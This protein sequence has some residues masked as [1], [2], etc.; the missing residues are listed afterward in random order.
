MI[1]AKFFL[2]LAFFF[3]TLEGEELEALPP[4]QVGDLVFRQGIGAESLIIEK[5]GNFPYTH[6]AMISSLEP[7][8]LIHATTNDNANTPNQVIFSPFDEFLKQSKKIAIKRLDLNERQKEQILSFAKNKLG[9][10]FEL[11]SDENALYCT[12]FIEKALANVV[13]YKLSKSYVDFAYFRGYYLFP[14][15]FFE[16]NRSVLIYESKELKNSKKP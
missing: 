14:K 1:R 5:L 15:A 10:E 9:E 11:S 16:D 7:L 8:T 12:T 6:I 3:A 2:F 4:L 13:E